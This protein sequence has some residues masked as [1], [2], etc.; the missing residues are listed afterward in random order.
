MV[1]GTGNGRWQNK[2]C[3]PHHRSDPET[4]TASKIVVGRTGNGRMPAEPQSP[5]RNHQQSAI[6]MF[7][8][9]PARQSA[10]FA[11]FLFGKKKVGRS[12][13]AK[14]FDF[15]FKDFDF[16][17]DFKLLNILILKLVFQRR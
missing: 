17:V 14:A 2:Q 3:V 16:D 15:D 12:G 10:F 5:P 6:P 9:L 1:A 8:P 4:N 7:L 11:Y 13:G